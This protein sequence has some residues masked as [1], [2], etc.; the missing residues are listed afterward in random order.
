MSEETMFEIKTIT[1]EIELR[2]D[3]LD[4]IGG[5][6]ANYRISPATLRDWRIYGGQQGIW[7]DKQRTRALT[8]GGNG[9]A[10]SLLH[11]G[12]IYPDDVD[13]TGIIYHYPVTNRSSSR[14]LG[15]IE[16]V[17]NCKRYSVPLFVIRVSENDP[18]ERDVFFGYVTTWDDQA[19]A[20]IIEFGLRQASIMETVS[21]RPFK[22]IVQEFGEKYEVTK[23]SNQAAFRIAVFRR[24]GFQCA[25][26]DVSVTD[27]L[28]AAHLV[29]KSEHGS[30]DPRNGI[31]LCALHHRAF[32]SNLFSIDP[33]TL[34]VVTRK[35]G[36]SMAELGITKHEISH[37]PVFPPREALNYC[38]KKWRKEF[39]A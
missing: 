19:K 5:K 39:D 27:L 18:T 3:L 31:P 8:K 7:V 6:A 30:D 38:W 33:S 32:D 21:E 25:V 29:S 17:K 2:R 36:P 26:C 4:R 37:L 20:F 23:R 34:A 35:K 24:Y 1:E 11:K 10:V 12:D 13:E 15:E 28:D 14:D 16:A 22:L 9:L